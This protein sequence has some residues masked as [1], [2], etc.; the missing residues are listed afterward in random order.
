MT[1]YSLFFICVFLPLF[2]FLYFRGTS[3]ES[4]NRILLVFSLIF[5]CWGGIKYLLLLLVMNG[6]AYVSAIFM[7]QQSTR[8]GKRPFLILALALFL[9]V[10]SLF[11][12]TG[13]FLG[14]LGTLLQKDWAFLQFALPLGISFYT[15]KLIS[16]VADVYNEKTNAASSYGTLLLYTCIFHQSISG[17]I[18]RYTDLAPQFEARRATLKH[19]V[20]GMTRFLVGLSKKTVLANHCGSLAATLLPLNS[21]ISSVPA[22]GVWFGSLF[23]MLQIYLD[24]SA[25]SDMAIGL[26]QMIGFHY[27]ENFNYPYLASSVK[28]FWRRWHISLSS[29]FRDYVYIPLGGSRCSEARTMLNLLAVW[30]LTGLW[31]G[32]NWNYIL[33]GLYYF[34]FIAFET[35]RSAKGWKELPL[36]LGHITTLF[37]IYFG[38]ILFRFKS[39][40][41]LGLTLK[42]LFGLNQ[43]GWNS[44]TVSVLLKNNLFFLLV[45]ILACTPFVT[46]SA[47]KLNHRLYS[48]ASS[49]GKA[50]ILRILACLLLL[51][52]SILA[53]IGNSYTPFL[54]TQ[55]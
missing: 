30:V 36:A 31:H 42:G 19:L 5:Y 55:F 28:D 16:Y 48:R 45:S 47:A 53:L 2:L 3:L 38:W 13:F 41:Q 52:V 9:A 29:F 18:E 43:N 17:P 26:G 21:E 4:Q 15:F 8:K 7:E 11:K 32:A 14:T 37:V 40:T 27:K 23:Y 35:Y 44:T 25:Y 24:F 22:C 39:L 33:W 10:L 34:V 1:F 12:Y 6:I 49:V 54:Y 50:M 46:Q 20:S 51:A